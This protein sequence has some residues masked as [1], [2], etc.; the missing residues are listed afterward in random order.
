MNFTHLNDLLTR[1]AGYPP[2]RIRLHPAPG[3][4]TKADARR[5][6]KIE[7]PV[8]EVVEGVLV[9]KDPAPV[10]MPTTLKLVDHI[11]A[12]AR[13]E[14]LGIVVGGADAVLITTPR[15]MRIPM[16]AFY[17]RATLP[18]CPILSGDWLL[19][20]LPL[21]VVPDLVIEVMGMSNT[22]REMEEKRRDYFFA[23]VKLAWFIDPRART[24]EVYTSPDQVTTLTDADTLAGG[25]VLPGF[26][27]PVGQLF[28]ATPPP[29]GA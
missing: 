16:V 8:C 2:E 4:A 1:F 12:F 26:S 7:G 19:K 14:R 28:T 13:G 3:T 22:A 11:S 24:V 9:E 18:D 6:R 5:V 21:E 27:L 23:G 10:M 15:A 20:R 25:D 17:R 29:E